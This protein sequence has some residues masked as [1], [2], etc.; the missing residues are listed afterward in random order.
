MDDEAYARLGAALRP[1][2]RALVDEALAV[3]AVVQP[4]ASRIERLEALAQEFLGAYP[5][6][7]HVPS[8]GAVLL[9]LRAYGDRREAIEAETERW[10]ALPE[11]GA[12]PAPEARFDDMATAQ[13]IDVELRELAR[14]RS[15]WDDR[16]R[17]SPLVLERRAV[18]RSPRPGLADEEEGRNVSAEISW[19]SIGEADDP[20]A[21]ALGPV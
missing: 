20:S 9:P 6:E 4:G 16:S 2:E 15:D 3:A 11:V 19:E 18:A 13:A 7:A 17:G 1:D 10:A 21:V 12:L 8:A 5:S 14:L